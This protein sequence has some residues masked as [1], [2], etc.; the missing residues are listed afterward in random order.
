MVSRVSKIYDEI[1]TLNSFYMKVPKNSNLAFSDP[2]EVEKT[3]TMKLLIGLA[4]ASSGG[5]TVFG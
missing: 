5:G 3:T 1:E 2:M 4:R